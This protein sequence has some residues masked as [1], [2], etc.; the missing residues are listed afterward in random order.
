MC[1]RVYQTIHEPAHFIATA[2][3]RGHCRIEIETNKAPP[4]DTAVGLC[5][6]QVVNMCYLVRHAQ[7]I[8]IGNHVQI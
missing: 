7:A 6:A 3:L 4:A 1:V 2:S 8:R 5:V